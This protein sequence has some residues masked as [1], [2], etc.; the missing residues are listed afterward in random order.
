MAYGHPDRLVMI[1][2]SVYYKA[3]SQIGTEVN[4]LLISRGFRRNYAASELTVQILSC[5]QH[6]CVVLFEAC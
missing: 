3:L 2:Q 1:F 4:N 6:Q 5:I